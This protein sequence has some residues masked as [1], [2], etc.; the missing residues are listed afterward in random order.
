MPRRSV[1]ATA[2]LAAS[3]ATTL[4]A[5]ACAPRA[6]PV[7]GSPTG[8]PPPTASAH[9]SP[10]AASTPATTIDLATLT[11]RIAFSGGPH[12]D[13][14]VYVV[15]ADGSGL[16]QITEAPAAEF[17]PTWAPD[18]RRVAYRHQPTDDRS[19]DIYVIDSDG[20]G[21]RNLSGDDGTPDWGPAW[22]PDGAWIGWNTAADAEFGFDLG[23]I[24]P[25]GGGR[26]IIKPGVFVEYPAWSPD[27]SRIAFMSQVAAEGS[28]YDVFAMNADGSDVRR[29]TTSP[30][31]DGWPTWSPD[32]TTIAFSSE[33]DDCGQS[34]VPDCLSTGDIGPFHTLYL[35]AP[36]GSGQRR[37]SALFAQI[38]DWSPD[39][40]FLVFEGRSGLTVVSADGREVGTI[41]VGVTEPGFPDWID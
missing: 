14:E 11:G 4:L 41:A 30:G 25:D 7:S 18:S 9:A 29:L 32:G 39:G 13:L 27:G 2:L 31:T 19:T 1:R 34:A 40:R 6:Q 10:V 22:S 37:V 36:D 3:L 16:R 5:A 38:A 21:A 23:L 12:P 26:T 20:S 24:H 33:R 17:D 15:N 28:Q 8:E 35:M